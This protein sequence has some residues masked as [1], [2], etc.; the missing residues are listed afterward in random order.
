M[1]PEL[2][3]ICSSM[4]TWRSSSS[5][6]A[7][8][9]PRSARMGGAIISESGG[10]IIPLRGATSSRNWG[11]FLRNQ[12]TYAQGPVGA[13]VSRNSVLLTR[14]VPPTVDLEYQAWLSL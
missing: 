11:G 7:D 2:A 14:I 3:P 5:A 8:A 13:G 12:H 9:A 10:G 4:G 1:R 6:R